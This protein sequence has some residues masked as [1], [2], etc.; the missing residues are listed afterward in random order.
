[1]I[2]DAK[3]GKA[4]NADILNNFKKE[5]EF[6]EELGTTGDLS[7]ALDKSF[8]LTVEDSLNTIWGRYQQELATKYLKHYEYHHLGTKLL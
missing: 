5:I 4:G 8:N 2:D 1:M 7:K 6:I 3:T